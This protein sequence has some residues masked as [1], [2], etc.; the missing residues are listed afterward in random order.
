MKKNLLVLFC[1]FSFNTAFA[2][3]IDFEDLAGDL[4]TPVADGYN[5]LNWNTLNTTGIVDINP[6]L[7]P[8]VDYTGLQN[9]A[10]F[11]AFGY[12]APNTTIISAANGGT[13]DFLSGFWSA[14]LTGMA[15]VKFEGY[16]NNQ[17]MYSSNTYNLNG[18]SVAPVVL[19]WFGI[20][21]FSI[22]SSADVWIADNLEVNIN[23]SAVPVPAAIWL[24]GSALLG[25]AGLRRKSV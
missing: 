9:N 14:G 12:V 17:L 8:G 3:T 18:N 6:F 10:L 13:F 4:V 24:L 11:N 16:A 25:F 19:N 2:Q 1:F 20:D 22:V 7:V 23:P 5:G 15:D 21:S